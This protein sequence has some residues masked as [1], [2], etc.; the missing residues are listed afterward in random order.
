MLKL[1]VSQMEELFASIASE[2]SLYLPLETNGLIAFSR[3]EEGKQARFD[4]LHCAGSVKDFFFPQTEN[5]ALFKTSGKEIHIEENRDP[6][7][8]FV[9]FGVRACDAGSLS[10]LDRVFYDEPAD[11]FYQTRRRQGLIITV[12]CNAPEETCFCH[13]FGLDAAD[14]GG[15]VA[16]WLL[17]DM[18]YWDSRTE[19]GHALTERLRGLFE[20]AGDQGEETVRKGKADIGKIIDR[21][22]LRDLSLERFAGDGMMEK[23]DAPQWESL[24]EACLGCGT[25]TFVCPT[26]HCYDIRDF[27]TGHGIRRFR[28]WDSCMFSDFTLMAHGNPRPS[29]LA[30]FRQRFMHKLAY[31]PENHEG[32][33]A[34]VGC[35]RCIT[36]CP[37]SMNITK[38]IKTLGVD[39]HA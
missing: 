30:R 12:A 17:E 21:L 22:P 23:F 18:L 13:T 39:Q 27:D 14:P 28:C 36:K 33:Y 9:V 3:W 31:Y 1:P 34:C 24:Q 7:E 6:E 15:D 25:C 32:L 5:L 19:K 4:Q 35:G 38:V 8:A 2:Q 16:V 11:T 26:C 20:E 29:R 37:V 10:I